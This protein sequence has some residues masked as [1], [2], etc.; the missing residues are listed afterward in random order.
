M[1]D[2]S[3]KGKHGTDGGNNNKVSANLGKLHWFGEI[4]VFSP[5]WL[6]SFGKGR[7]LGLVPVRVAFAPLASLCC[8][9][10][11]RV[12]RDQ[13]G[14][15]GSWQDFDIVSGRSCSK[16]WGCS[17]LLARYHISITGLRD[18][19]WT[20]KIL[21]FFAVSGAYCLE[22]LEENHACLVPNCWSRAK[23]L[24]LASWRCLEW[25]YQLHSLPAGSS[26]TITAPLL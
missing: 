2:P 20:P 9:S 16:C 12:G 7:L 25:L 23:T 18:M 19:L 11:L 15:L 13:A 10:V 1:C 3:P 17:P 14:P 4:A 6:T 26:R 8:L 22:L 21:A 24:P 5:R